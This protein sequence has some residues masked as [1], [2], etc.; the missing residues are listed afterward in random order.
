MTAS[1]RINYGTGSL[2]GQH[3]A[4]AV[5]YTVKAQQEIARAKAIGDAITAGGATQANMDA[6][7]EFGNPGAGVGAV[8]YSAI[9]TLQT[10]LENATPSQLANLDPGF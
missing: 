10:N 1:T 2:A 4:L 7:V 8:L 5:S 9:V 6:C 3:L